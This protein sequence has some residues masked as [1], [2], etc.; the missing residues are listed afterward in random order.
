M[1]QLLRT[2]KG[3]CYLAIL[4]VDIFDLEH[5]G[6][7]YLKEVSELFKQEYEALQ[8]VK[9]GIPVTD[10]VLTRENLTKTM[11]R[12]YMSWLGLFTQ[13]SDVSQALTPRVSS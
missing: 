6:Q 11:L 5:K 3:Q 10:R 4:P 2:K 1:S 8:K 7:G 13:T 12:E 9:Q